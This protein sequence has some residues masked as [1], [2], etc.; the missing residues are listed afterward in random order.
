MYIDFFSTKKHRK[1]S[2]SL[3]CSSFAMSLSLSAL[4]WVQFEKCSV[5]CAVCSVQ[6]EVFIVWVQCAVFN[7]QS[8]MCSVPCLVFNVHCVVCSVPCL[9]FN[10]IYVVC[11]V[12]SMKWE[13][14]FARLNIHLDHQHFFI[15]SSMNY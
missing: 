5:K 4:T 8:A 3:K 14:L 1:I 13:D 10:V 9:V 15:P 12:H 7:V 6:R 11:N 2:D